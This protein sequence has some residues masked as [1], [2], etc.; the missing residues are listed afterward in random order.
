MNARDEILAKLRET[1][2]Q[3]SLRFPP[4][5]TPLLDIDRMTVTE[6]EGGPLELALRFG[7]ELLALHG[8]YEIVESPAEARLSLLN[9]LTEWIDAEQAA[10]KGAVIQ[11]G[12]ERSVL[13]WA[14]EFLPVD[15]LVP[16]L[17]DMNLLLVTPESLAT[18]QEREAIRFI[19]YGVTGADAAF[20]STGSMLSISEPGKNRVASLL[21]YYHIALIPFSRLYPT[22]EAWLAA[23]REAGTL[24]AALSDKA[25]V[26]IIT[27]P[28]KSAD[29]E[30]NL[31]LGV[32]GPKH[33]HAVL[34]DDEPVELQDALAFEDE[35][36]EFEDVAPGFEDEYHD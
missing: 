20:A 13:S 24:V 27:G 12:Q 36:L 9:R 21:P 15:G 11:T 19:R 10:Q 31:T 30:M 23:Q 25:N 8:T 5:D 6:A 4:A 35:P 34:F 29:I 16:A 7:Q 32:H 18:D 3:P 22:V 17:A 1:L 33:V 28:S 2:A 14:P 26:T